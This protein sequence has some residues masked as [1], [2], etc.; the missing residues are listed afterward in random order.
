[1]LSGMSASPGSGPLSADECLTQAQAAARDGDF[2]TAYDLANR[3]L[4]LAPG[5]LRL[6]HFAILSIAL[7]GATRQAQALFEQ[8]G[9]SG[10]TDEDIITL[11]AR[12]AKDRALS[13][14]GDERT[15]LA[16]LAADRY[17]TVYLRTN[18]LYAKI[19]AAT[20]YLVAG[21]RQ[22]AAGLAEQ[23]LATI[24]AQPD[25]PSS[26]AE[27]DRYYRLATCAEAALLLGNTALAADRLRH[28]RSVAP[29]NYAL[30]ATIRKQL[31]LVCELLGHDPLAVLAPL[32]P[33][34][35]VHYTGHLRL[36]PADE[37]RITGELSRYFD[38]HVPGYGSGSLAS[39]GDILIAEA[40]LARGAKLE[41]VLP[42]ARER[43]RQDIVR[44]AGA[45][46]GA[47]FDACLA[48]SRTRIIE[49]ASD[50]AG[51]D[52]LYR[53]GS[54]IAMGLALVRA[55]SLGTT[56]LQ[57]AVWDE[58]PPR[59]QAGTA[60][61]VAA[62]RARGLET[63]VLHVERDPAGGGPVDPPP[64]Q[65]RVL[66]ALLFGDVKGFSK[67][68]EAQI[69]IFIEE[70]MG[71]FARVIERHRDA[72]E[73]VNTWGDGLYLVLR[74]APS[75]ARC[76]LEL[77]AALQAL[78]PTKFGLP[79]HLALRIGAHYGPVYQCLDPV[80]GKTNASGTHVTRAAR[81]EPVTPVGEVYGTEAFA[82][83]LAFEDSEAI[84][85][86]AGQVPLAKEYGSMRMYLVSRAESV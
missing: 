70:V 20:L 77:Q 66:R 57:L 65:P 41:V 11:E 58:G 82:A 86:Y 16:Y 48:C 7:S 38:T 52:A 80:L 42:Y 9:L 1:M 67:L 19:N 35:V 54:R 39:G 27:H 2:L 69:P 74:D 59:G 22:R 15:R 43:F 34:L 24:D 68:Q 28:A 26:M 73:Q 18:S 60:V 72:V 29:E 83:A 53:Y 84:C 6:R 63:H 4:A 44:H 85:H 21:D 78:D 45:S 8:S 76:A 55:R 64:A 47:R 5:N 23:L 37:A 31:R 61:E 32:T 36:R 46:W 75:A 13:A 50:E 25:E 10:E 40:L 33:P 79:P 51:E 14:E 71:T 30:H 56:A 62:W 81:I 12:L 3:G 49:A 17:I